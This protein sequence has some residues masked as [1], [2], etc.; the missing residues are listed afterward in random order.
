MGV[1][2][3]AQEESSGIEDSGWGRTG[4]QKAAGS[5]AGCRGRMDKLVGGG[6]A[7]SGLWPNKHQYGLRG[8]V[9]KQAPATSLV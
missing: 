2:S 1:G 9:V 6:M 7:Q 5:R 8:A 4:V 3:C